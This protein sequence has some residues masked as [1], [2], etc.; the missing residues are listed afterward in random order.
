MTASASIDHVARQA[1]LAKTASRRL[2]LLSSDDKKRILLAI[3]AAI[4]ASGQDILFRNEIDVEASKEAG[5]QEA[6]IERLVLT[7][8]S[9]QSMAQGVR[10]IAE[11]ADPVGE[12]IEDWARPSGIRI[13]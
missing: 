4:G 3:A 11:Q 6:L 5:L 9:L 10:D 8:K 1:L 2:A 7:E 12:V 13:E